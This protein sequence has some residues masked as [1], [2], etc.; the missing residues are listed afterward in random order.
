MCRIPALLVTWCSE[1][2]PIGMS[3]AK[4]ELEGRTNGVDREQLFQPSRQRVCGSWDSVIA[5]LPPLTWQLRAREE[6][7]AK[8]LQQSLV[9]YLWNRRGYN[10]VWREV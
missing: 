3:H 6:E 9:Q 5:F 10:H 8:R 1:S 4:P 7:R 2:A